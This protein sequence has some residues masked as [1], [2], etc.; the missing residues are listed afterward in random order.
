MSKQM[1]NEPDDFGPD[2]NPATGLPML[3]DANVDVSGNPYG[4]DM[5]TWQPVYDP[6]MSYYTPPAP[7]FDQW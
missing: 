6:D 3:D 7:D 5:H 2:I 1:H 4:I